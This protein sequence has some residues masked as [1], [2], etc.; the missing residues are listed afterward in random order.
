MV[1]AFK[2]ALVSFRSSRHHP[3]SIAAPQVH[4]HVGFEKG[5][6]KAGQYLP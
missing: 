6:G 4:A 3:R 5:K 2:Q 1:S